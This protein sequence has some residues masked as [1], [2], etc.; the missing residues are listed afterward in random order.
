MNE[1]NETTQNFGELGK[2]SD[3]EDD[4]TQTPAIENTTATQSLGDT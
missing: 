1:G 2:K 4:S 3:V